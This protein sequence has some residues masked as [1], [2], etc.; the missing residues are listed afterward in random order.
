ML[1]THTHT[2]WLDG[3][4]VANMPDPPVPKTDMTGHDTIFL[5]APETSLQLL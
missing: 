3:F 5:W 2:H 1:H 4:R